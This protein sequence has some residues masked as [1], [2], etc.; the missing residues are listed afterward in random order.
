MGMPDSFRAF[1]EFHGLAE[2]WLKDKVPD[3]N[4]YIEIVNFLV[5]KDIQIL[6]SFCWEDIDDSKDCKDPSKVFSRFYT[7]LQRPNTKR[8]YWKEAFNLKQWW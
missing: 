6:K 4:Q 2:V 8:H 1:W 7:S 3:A 5:Q